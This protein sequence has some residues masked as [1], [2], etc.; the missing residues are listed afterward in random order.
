MPH[1]IVRQMLYVGPDR[2]L[3]I[4]SNRAPSGNPQNLQLE[5]DMIRYSPID[6]TD[7]RY[8]LTAS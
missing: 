7:L 1:A 6:Y 8:P 5:I 4:S 2:L 3:Q